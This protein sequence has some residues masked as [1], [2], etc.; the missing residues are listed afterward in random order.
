MSLKCEGG[1]RGWGLGIGKEFGEI[2]FGVR[3]K[4]AQH[5]ARLTPNTATPN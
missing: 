4:K 1:I 3:G 5:S 2:E